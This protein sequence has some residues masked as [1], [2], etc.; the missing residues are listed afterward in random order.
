[1]KMIMVE[2]QPPPSFFAPHPARRA[3]KKLFMNIYLYDVNVKISERCSSN[4][5]KSIYESLK[6]IKKICIY[7]SS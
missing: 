6:K 3:L 2:I 5:H 7:K 4:K 1:M